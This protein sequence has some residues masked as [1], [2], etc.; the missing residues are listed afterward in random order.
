MKKVH[1]C[2]IVVCKSYRDKDK[3]KLCN[4]DEETA[5]LI[6]CTVASA[7]VGCKINAQI[8]LS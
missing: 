7:R 3:R 2:G 5:D 4:M 1:M 8:V 6:K